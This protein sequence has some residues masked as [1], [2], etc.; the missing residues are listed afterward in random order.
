MT[1]VFTT[2]WG[3]MTGKRPGFVEAEKNRMR[4]C[5]LLNAGLWKKEEEI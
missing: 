3:L 1:S 4:R 2:M 5:G